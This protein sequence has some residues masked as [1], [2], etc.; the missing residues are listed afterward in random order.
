MALSGVLPSAIAITLVAMI[1]LVMKG[2]NLIPAA[3]L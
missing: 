1:I 2:M 3:L